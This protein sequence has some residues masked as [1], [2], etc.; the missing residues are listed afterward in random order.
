M[1]GIVTFDDQLDAGGVFSVTGTAG[2]SSD[3][4]ASP[5][6]GILAAAIV[7]VTRGSLELQGTTM[8]G[9]D[10]SFGVN[11][12]GQYFVGQPTN[13]MPSELIVTG[14]GGEGN[15]G[16]GISSGAPVNMLGPAPVFVLSGT[17]LQTPLLPGTTGVG[18]SMLDRF[19][20]TEVASVTVTGVSGFG[21]IAEYGIHYIGSAFPGSGNMELVLDGT[22]NGSGSGNSGVFVQGDLII[23]QAFVATGIAGAGVSSHG[24]SFSPSSIVGS[25]MPSSFSVSLDGTSSSSAGVLL[26]STGAWDFG[27][28]D[29]TLTVT[30]SMGGV[31]A[32]TVNLSTA[33][34]LLL[35]GIGAGFGGRGVVLSACTFILGS[36]ATASGTVRRPPEAPGGERWSVSD[37]C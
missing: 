27:S 26:A 29:V 31:R 21:I 24:V 17:A 7:T 11:F 6:H 25:G 28:G 20:S 12:Q 4:G 2:F 18:V 14:Q 1:S 10:G 13:N 5:C 16:H 36:D 22:S 23:D 8:G 3:A 34:G 9:P 19:T 30:S 37:Q 32:E 33:G 35:S 15:R